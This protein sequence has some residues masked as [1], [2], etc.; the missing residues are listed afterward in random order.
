[1][2]KQLLTDA[3]VRSVEL[4]GKAFVPYIMAGD[5]GL[6]KLK[7]DIL[8]LQESGV[9]AIE[10]G[11][12]FSDPVAD[13]PVIQ[14]AGE[15]A[16]TH[17][18][19]LRKVLQTIHSIKEE[20]TVPLV[21]MTYLNPIIRY[22]IDQFVADCVRSGVSGIIVPDLPLEESELLKPALQKGEIALIPLV[23]L[24]SPADRIKKIV[25]ES[26]GF[27]YAVTVNGITG[28]RDGFGDALETHLTKLKD[29]SPVPVLAG[30]GISTVKQV[31]NIGASVDG[32]IVGSAIVQ[33]LYEEEYEKVKSLVNAS[34]PIPIGK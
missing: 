28:V 25:A 19:T 14:A 31:Q 24:T 7:R 6:D 23:S 22:G 20:V 26:E 11:I 3:I 5:G 33:A 9:T 10:L 18:V 29:I 34:K 27:I 16:L 30:F 12:P 17:G 32:V 2:T 13:G 1:M 15:R 21:L 8:F 4:G